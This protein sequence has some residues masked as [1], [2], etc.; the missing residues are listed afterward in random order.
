MFEIFF[1][2]VEVFFNEIDSQ[3]FRKIDLLLLLCELK[4]HLPPPA[5][6]LHSCFGITKAQHFLLQI[7]EPGATKD[8]Q[9]LLVE[10]TGEE[11]SARPML[12]YFEPLME[13]LKTEN[14][15]REVGW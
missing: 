2:D 5:V 8:W 11:L 3:L 13:W 12:E 10:T 9:E 14:E 15:G 4:Q 6:K 1:L 7:M